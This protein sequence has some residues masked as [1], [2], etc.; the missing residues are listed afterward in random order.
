MKS[1]FRTA[2]SRR[3]FKE[4]DLYDWEKESN[5]T[6]N[7]V[8]K[9]DANPPVQIATQAPSSIVPQAIQSNNKNL[10]SE[11]KAL[12][13]SQP[14]GTVNN[15]QQVTEA[16]VADERWK[17]SRAVTGYS[18][19]SPHSNRRALQ[20]SLDRAN[21]RP[22]PSSPL[23]VAPSNGNT[24]KDSSISKKHSTSSRLPLAAQ[25]DKNVALTNLS[26][27]VRRSNASKSVAADSSTPAGKFVTKEDSPASG[28]HSD[29]NKQKPQTAPLSTFP[30]RLPT[31]K[32]SDQAA[33]LVPESTGNNHNQDDNQ[34]PPVIMNT[35][36]TSV[37]HGKPPKTPRLVR[38]GNSRS[39]APPTA[40][41]GASIRGG[42]SEAFS[43]AP[44]TYAMKAGIQT[45][46]SQWILSLDEN[47]DDEGSDN[48][49]SAKWDDAQEKNHQ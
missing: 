39:D 2:I 3:S 34:S 13:T 9:A 27:H 16:D 1:I 44:A 21:R 41:R 10:M 25:P 22:Y 40:F 33:A 46:M 35:S 20:K 42:D 49:H 43:M 8:G 28:S 6:E 14:V 47:I 38:Q 19:H 23:N 31:N 37:E 45:A 26:Q 12:V 30:N 17:S 24:D 4:S 29:S 15:R 18:D 11:T 7:E 36:T 48:Q 32:S 5:G